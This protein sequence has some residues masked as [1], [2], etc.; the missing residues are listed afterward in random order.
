MTHTDLFSGNLSPCFN[1]LMVQTV[2]GKYKNNY[3]EII[4]VKLLFNAGHGY[5]LF[6]RGLFGKL[7]EFCN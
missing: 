5:G 6:L 1:I 4:R 3:I 2:I 7:V